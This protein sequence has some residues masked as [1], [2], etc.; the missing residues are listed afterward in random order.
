[1]CKR[2]AKLSS[3]FCVGAAQRWRSSCSG[4][5]YAGCILLHFQT[6][7]TTQSNCYSTWQ[8]GFTSIQRSKQPQAHLQSRLAA[9]PEGAL[10]A[11]CAHTVSMATTYHRLLQLSTF[12]C[13]KALRETPASLYTTLQ[14]HLQSRLAAAPEGAPQPCCPHAVSMATT[15]HKLLQLSTFSCAN[16]L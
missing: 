5:I 3:K 16:P 8:A 15:Y 11:S 7:Q 13:A 2:L 9:A 6:R 10:Q 12:S 4:R 1:M 14:A